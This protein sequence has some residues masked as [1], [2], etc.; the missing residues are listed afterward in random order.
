[1]IAQR[2]LNFPPISHRTVLVKIDMLRALWGVDSET[3]S[4]K[5]DAGE[6]LWA[7]DVSAGRGEV[8]ELRFWV[9]ELIAPETV[10]LTPAQTIQSVLGEGRTRWRGVEI[11][12]LLL[13]SRPHIFKLHESGELPGDII[14]GVLYVQR[15]AVRAFLASRLIGNGNN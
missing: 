8:R 14:S 12:Q 9:R 10:R 1:M 4:A 6:I 3:I 5:V 11:A 2:L 7:W 15:E 13:V